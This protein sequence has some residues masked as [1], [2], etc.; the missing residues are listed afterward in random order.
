MRVL[1]S[2]IGSRG[3][4]QPLVALGLALKTRGAE[5]R[6]CVP[7]DFQRWI[8]GMG[9]P[10]TPV[11]PELRSTGKV[12]PLAAP[13]TA[14]QKR[15]MIEAT[16]VTQFE[17]I[18]QAARGCDLI[19]GA[20]ALQIAAP[21]VAEL[22]SIPYRFVA[23]CPSVLPSPSHA[24]VVHGALASFTD[25]QARDHREQWARHADHFAS[26]FSSALNDQRAR[27]GLSPIDDVHR[28]VLTDAPWLA[29]DPALAPFPDDGAVFQPGAFILPDHRALSPELERFLGAGPPPIY[30][31]F[32]SNRATE[33]LSQAMTG[34]ARALGYRA[35]ISRGWAEL[36]APDGLPDCLAIAE[37]NQQ[38][39]FKRVAA[40]V[41]HGGAGTTTAAARA[42]VPQVIIPQLYDQGYWGQRVEQLG[43]G[44]AHAPGA[45]TAESLT[46]ALR[47]TLQERVARRA[48][49][50]A[51]S[52]RAEGASIAAARLFTEWGAAPSC[53]R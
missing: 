36:S 30:F 17:A 23:Y 11:G 33:G 2:T 9:L 52:I 53:A 7:P 26:T 46:L 15:L 4:V 1:L 28:Y 14:D 38:A 10:V 3:D 29:A 44:A 20:T 22:R 27:R 35:L 12:R 34:A 32:G 24:P 5:V 43:I 8:E 50:F 42:G 18:E 51:S 41:H 48:R 47:P 16:V 40:V 39:L 25:P 13:P 45:P 21:S 49:S 37:V 31:G 19:V 6:L